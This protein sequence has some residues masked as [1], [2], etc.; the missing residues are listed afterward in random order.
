MTSRLNR[1][2]R[3]GAST[4]IVWPMHGTSLPGALHAMELQRHL[5]HRFTGRH[6]DYAGLALAA[7]ISWVGI[8]GPGEAALM[9][10]ASPQLAATSTS[11]G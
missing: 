10:P 5:H 1:S 9:R 7:A 4:V 2:P 11:S 6:V 3:P 8:T